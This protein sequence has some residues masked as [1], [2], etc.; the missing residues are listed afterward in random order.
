VL[1]TEYWQTVITI[2]LF[3]DLSLGT[4]CMRLSSLI[5]CGLLTGMWTGCSDV[6]EELKKPLAM[7]QVP[8]EILKVAKEKYP[9]LVF[10][11]AYTE[12]EDGQPVYELKGK[13]SSGKMM[14][15]EVTKDGKILE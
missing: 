8:A 3:L 6:N 12:V 13:A 5:V 10:E 9:D 14:E 7:D 4:L 15:V 1:S 2:L 11:A